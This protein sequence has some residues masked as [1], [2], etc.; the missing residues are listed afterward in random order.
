MGANYNFKIFLPPCAGRQ[1]GIVKTCERCIGT[2]NSEILVAVTQG[3]GNGLLH[4][5]VPGKSLCVGKPYVAGG[6]V[7]MIYRTQNNLQR[8]SL[9]S[10]Y[11]IN[12]PAIACDLALQLVTDA[13]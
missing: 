10:H 8:T 13:Y 12:T 11:K 1:R 2:H 6:K 3:K 4:E 9:R 7:D 5:S